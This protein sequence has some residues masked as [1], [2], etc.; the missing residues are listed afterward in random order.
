MVII[1]R[2]MSLLTLTIT[3]AVMITDNRQHDH[4]HDHSTGHCIVKCRCNGF[5][6]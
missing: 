5:I 6:I 3:N 1:V 2:D 4:D